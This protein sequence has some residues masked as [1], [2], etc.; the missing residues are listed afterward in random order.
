MTGG[1]VAVGVSV[2]V[3]V[4]TS[5][6]V[7]VGE[8]VEVRVG[9]VEVRVGVA[10]G[11][12]SSFRIVPVALPVPSTAFVGA[13]SVTVNVSSG[14]TSR[15]PQTGM[16][17]VPVVLLAATVTVPPALMKSTPPVQAGPPVAVPLASV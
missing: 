3:A 7:G 16:L 17:I 12:A 5:V 13:P 10:V 8:A 9:V 4:G 15:S 14:S 6:P 2:G 11:A 1:E